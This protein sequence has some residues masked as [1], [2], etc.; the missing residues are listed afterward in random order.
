[1]NDIGESLQ[2]EELQEQRKEGKRE[3]TDEEVFQWRGRR[4]SAEP[5]WWRKAR[6]LSGHRTGTVLSPQPGEIGLGLHASY[7]GV[8]HRSRDV[9][10][11]GSLAVGPGCRGASDFLPFPQQ[12]PVLLL[13]VLH[14]DQ[15]RDEAVLHLDLQTLIKLTM[16]CDGKDVFL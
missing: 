5:P 8:T 14:V 1:M 11:R 9:R 3:Q 15:Q 2:S 13:P 4:F 6:D 16:K 7:I 12:L 10:A